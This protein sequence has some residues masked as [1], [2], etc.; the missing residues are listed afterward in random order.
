M[1]KTIESGTVSGAAFCMQKIWKGRIFEG[2]C[3]TIREKGA[4]GHA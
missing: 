4:D 1:Y 2:Y 3:G